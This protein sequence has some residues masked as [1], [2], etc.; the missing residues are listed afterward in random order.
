MDIGMM[1]AVE[2]LLPSNI[3]QVMWNREKKDFMW[4]RACMH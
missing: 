1:L 2:S 3:P 4:M